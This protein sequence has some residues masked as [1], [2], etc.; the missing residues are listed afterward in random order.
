[1]SVCSR[2][3]C[4]LVNLRSMK[5]RALGEAERANNAF[6]TERRDMMRSLLRAAARQGTLPWGSVTRLDDFQ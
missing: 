3:C 2:F 4:D 1:M 6:A 5:G